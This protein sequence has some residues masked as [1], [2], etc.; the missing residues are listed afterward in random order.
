MVV[1]PKNSR[2]L[3]TRI[4]IVQW[5]KNIPFILILFGLFFYQVQ[6]MQSVQQIKFSYDLGNLV[7]TPDGLQPS[8]SGDGIFGGIPYQGEGLDD[9]FSAFISYITND[10]SDTVNITEAE[11][12]VMENAT[13][14]DII[15]DNIGYIPLIAGEIYQAYLDGELNLD[16]LLEFLL[17]LWSIAF[18]FHIPDSWYIPVYLI[19]I[20][21]GWFDISRF[22]VLG[23]IR[24]FDNEDYFINKNDTILEARG[25]IH[26]NFT[27]FDMVKSLFF[28]RFDFLLEITIQSIVESIPT[29]IGSFNEIFFDLLIEGKPHFMFEVGGLMGLLGMQVQIDVDLEPI[30]EGLI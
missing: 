19:I 12:Q 22:S 25:E 5:I 28:S 24:W 29:S 16:L 14:I 13:L 15:S 18:D 2:E 3:Q 11:L 1:L 30:L 7:T 20:N 4:N 23:G 27:I 21:D 8:Q 17:Q 10:L 6:W 26:V 9:F